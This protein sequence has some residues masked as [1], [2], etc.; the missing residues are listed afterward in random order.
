MVVVSI[1]AQPLGWIIK[2]LAVIL[3]I[4]HRV[5]G[6]HR[7]NNRIADAYVVATCVPVGT[8]GIYIVFTNLVDTCILE[9]VRR[10]Q[11]LSRTIDADEVFAQ[12][13]DTGGTWIRILSLWHTTT[14]IDVARTIVVHKNGWVEQPLH[15]TVRHRTG[16]Q[17]LSVL[18]ILPWSVR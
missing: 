2:H 1:V 14:E 11:R 7:G 12:L 4:F 17:S 13:S 10:I 15:I 9:E 6:N 3:E 5:G 8:I 16:D 18:H